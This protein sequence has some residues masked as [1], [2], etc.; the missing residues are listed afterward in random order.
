MTF[1][2]LFV[3]FA[4]VGACA[5]VQR[6]WLSAD[7]AFM[8]GLS[9]VTVAGV[10]EPDEAVRGF[11]NTV[12][13]AIASL[14]II[15]AGLRQAG[16]VDRLFVRAVE[17]TIEQR[18]WRRTLEQLGLARLFD[19]ASPRNI[20]ASNSDGETSTQ[21]RDRWT[22]G[23]IL[24][25]L[26]VLPATGTVR[27]ETAAI[28]GATSVVV[29]GLLSPSAA[30]RAVKWEFVIVIGAILGFSKAF[31]ATGVV[32]TMRAWVPSMSAHIGSSLPVLLMVASGGLLAALD[33]RR[34]AASLLPVLCSAGLVAS[35]GMGL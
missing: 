22:G 10:I 28:L 33:R 12:V 1:D 32:D 20:E 16:L 25:S 6:E 7:A 18:D 23:A 17:G 3:L 9:L 29:S 30:R 24:A 4:L 5:L 31:I 14:Y 21:P 19:I 2:A 35:M 26:V 34:A 8:T 15:M 13:V 11:A 27:F